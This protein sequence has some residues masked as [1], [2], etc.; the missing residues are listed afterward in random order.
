MVEVEF[1]TSDLY[2]NGVGFKSLIDGTIGYCSLLHCS[3][4]FITHDEAI[5]MA[6]NFGK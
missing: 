3:P 6:E 5:K 2:G 1:Y 4:D